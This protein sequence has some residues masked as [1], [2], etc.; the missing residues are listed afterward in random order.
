MDF[1]ANISNNLTL[2]V[3][4]SAMVGVQ[5]FKFARE[6]LRTGDLSLH[7]L[8][9]TGGMPSSHSALVTSLATATGLQFGFGSAFFSISCVLALIVM[10]DARGVRQESGQHAR[11]LNQIV[12]ELFSG[13]TISEREL[14]ELLG[15]T[16]IEV[17]VGALVGIVYTLL[18]M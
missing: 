11:I 15:H 16:T 5:I 4:L 12:R 14:K 1:F 7:V 10:Y 9:S 13:H 18:V 3:P 17:F 6:W 2:L 8:F